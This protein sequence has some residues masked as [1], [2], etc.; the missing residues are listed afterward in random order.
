MP[1]EMKNIIKIL[2]LVCFFPFSLL[3]F[4]FRKK[5]KKGRQETRIFTYSASSAEN[6]H[7]DLMPKIDELYSAVMRSNDYTSAKARRLEEL[8]IRDVSL[9]PDVWI[10][11]KRSSP[12]LRSRPTYP[13]H[14]QLA[15]LYE[16]RGEYDKAIDVCRKAIRAGYNDDG[17][18]MKMSGR[19]ERLKEKA[20]KQK[21]TL[22]R[23]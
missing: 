1:D 5:R 15:T 9:A 14:R 11:M 16:R 7:F 12:Q 8:C 18:Q 4:L 6:E 2:L 23:G 13:S 22:Y 10:G 19:I 20:A 17:T 21:S 3:Y